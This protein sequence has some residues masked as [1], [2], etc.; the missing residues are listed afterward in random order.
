[1]AETYQPT[2]F[3]QLNTDTVVSPTPAVAAGA[4]GCYMS[5]EGQ[6]VRWRDDGTNPTAALGLRMAITGVNPFCYHGD[7]GRL[8]FLGEAA[9][10]KVNLSFFK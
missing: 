1:M 10:G 5:A 7:P 6:V 3:E 4:K 9:G 2:G 8:R